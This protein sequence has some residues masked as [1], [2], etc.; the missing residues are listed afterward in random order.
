[1]AEARKPASAIAWRSESSQWGSNAR[2]RASAHPRQASTSTAATTAAAIAP[3]ESVLE[4]WGRLCRTKYPSTVD[5][6]GVP[7][8]P[9]PVALIPGRD[10]RS[11]GRD[12]RPWRYVVLGCTL[13]EAGTAVRAFALV[14]VLGLASA[15][16]VVGC[17]LAEAGTEAV[18]G[19][20]V[21]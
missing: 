16:T 17:T 20:L 3:V 19:E 7:V 4:C 8:V 1:V 9:A 15:L 13:A 11:V 10:G 6:A 5:L 12:V 2:R 18:G 21:G 14:S